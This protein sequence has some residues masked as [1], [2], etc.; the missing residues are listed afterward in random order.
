MSEK[1]YEILVLTMFMLAG[2]GA[3]TLAKEAKDT[4]YKHRLLKHGKA[5]ES[6]SNRLLEIENEKVEENKELEV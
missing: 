2:V 1:S 3:Y 5:L 4:Y 6:I